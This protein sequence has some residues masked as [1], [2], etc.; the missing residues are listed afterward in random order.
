MSKEQSK[1]TEERLHELR[2]KAAEYA[3]AEAQRDYLSH[4]RKS[5]LAMLMKTYE[6]DHKTTAAQERE[7]RAD[8]KYIELLEGL[9]E[10]TETAERLK[11]ELNIAR[12]AIGIWRTRQANKRTEMEGYRG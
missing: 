1:T 7:A 10:A 2:E 11:W 9:R 12:D 4:Y 5:K 3:R 8:P 6:K